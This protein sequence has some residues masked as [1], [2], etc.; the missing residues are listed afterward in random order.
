MGG[1]EAGSDTGKKRFVRRGH[2]EEERRPSDLC[3]GGRPGN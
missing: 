3:I 2:L 1:K